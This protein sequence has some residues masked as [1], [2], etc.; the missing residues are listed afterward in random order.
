MN[1]RE[2]GNGLIQLFY[3]SLCVGCGVAL[4]PNEAVL[5][6]GCHSEIPETNYHHIPENETALRI[7]GRIPFQFATSYSYFTADGLMQQLLHALKYKHNKQVGYFLGRQFAY[8]LLPAIHAELP[9]YL[10]PVPLHA[11][12]EAIRGFNQSTVLAEGMGEV[13]GIPVADHVLVRSRMTQTQTKKSREERVK[14]ME[15]AFYIT[16][17]EIFKDKHVLIIDDVLTTGS[18]IESCVLA[19]LKVEKIKISVF[20]G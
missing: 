11:Q 14:N 17:T 13:L 4:L 10:V 2:I 6:L 19:L 7:A 20:S 1:L 9:Q 12:K 18:T 3:P 16:D 8:S 5:C 15:D